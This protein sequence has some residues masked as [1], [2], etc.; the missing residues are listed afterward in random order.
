M[1]VG[2][3]IM[4][5]MTTEMMMRMVMMIPGD[6]DGDKNKDDDDDEDDDNG[7]DD[8]THFLTQRGETWQSFCR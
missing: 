6:G 2:M 1:I 8:G 4:A 7:D 3:T 5:V